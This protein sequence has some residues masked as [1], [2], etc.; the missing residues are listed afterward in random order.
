MTRILLV[1]F[2]PPG[3][4]EPMA[5]LGAQLRAQ[6][7]DV[8]VFAGSPTGRWRLGGPLPAAL[9]FSA[10][11]GT[12]F[13]H[14]FLGD[15]EDMTRDIAD[16]AREHR[17]DLIVADVMMPGG[18]LAAELLGLPWVSLCCS[19]VPEPD[20]YRHF[21]PAH[22]VDAFAPQTTLK[23]L[24]LPDDGHN[25]LG[26]LSPWL[27]LIPTTPRF[28]GVAELPAPVRLVGPLAPTAS[29][30]RPRTPVENPTV[31]VSASTAAAPTLAGAAYSQDRYLAAVAEALGGLEVTGLVTHPAG[32]VEAP[33]NV[34]FLGPT[35]HDPL[36]DQAAAVVTH[37][38][39]GT[40]SRAL[41]RGLPLVLVPIANDQHHI[42]DRCAELG[43]GIT[44]PADRVTA[45]D[46]RAA[47]RAVLEEPGYRAAA[48]EFAA[49]SR[50]LAPLPTAAAL[51]SSTHALDAVRKG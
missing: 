14:L 7:H 11:G 37:A 10:D 13:R 48:A 46:L 25:L 35:P 47:V 6:G 41:V 31:V 28:A 27:H 22:A 20:A 49:E 39:W 38:G 12:L 16:H 26:R 43:L 24:G 3:H 33:A 1:P 40:V 4:T 34:R 30:P 50:A 23:A 32:V 5:A 18:G 42:A 45:A 17:A 19:P 9:V 29:A 36:F 44:L 15:V 51:I 8:A 21:I 2:H